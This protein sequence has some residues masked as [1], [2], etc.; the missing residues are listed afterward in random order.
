MPRHSPDFVLGGFIL[1]CVSTS[2][3]WALNE[4]IQ[5]PPST[6]SDFLCAMALGMTLVVSCGLFIGLY[7]QQRYSR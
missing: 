5:W 3:L 7:V 4:A 6:L 2:S 1:G